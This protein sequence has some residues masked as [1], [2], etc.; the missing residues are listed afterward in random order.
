[1]AVEAQK[2]MHERSLCKQRKKNKNGWCN[3]GFRRPPPRIVDLAA[4]AVACILDV[5]FP[6]RTKNRIQDNVSSGNVYNL[7]GF[8]LK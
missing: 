7:C 1:V 3:Y 5:D 8:C 6:Q 4:R 2:G